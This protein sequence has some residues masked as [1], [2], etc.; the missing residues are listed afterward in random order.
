[1][2]TKTDHNKILHIL[3][4]SA[5]KIALLII[6][7]FILSV[8]V[9][10]LARL[11]PGDP[12]HS[13]FGDAADRMT[14]AQKAA[15]MDKMGLN[16]SVI[17]QYIVWITNFF[18][19]NLGISYQYKQPVVNIIGNLWI[20]TLVL[21][22]LS[23][24]LTFVFAIFVGVFCAVRQNSIIDN[25]IRKVGTASSTIPSFF[26]ALIFILIFS[27][28]L[29]LLPMGGAYEPGGE[30][31]TV[32]RVVHLILPLSVMILSHLWY[33]AYMIRNKMIEELR[34]D[35]VLLLKVKGVSRRIIIWKHCFRNILPSLIAI[36]TVS[37][38]H[39]IGGT[40]VVETVFS[41]P[42]LGKLSFESA[43]YH[44]YNMLSA[45]CLITGTLVLISNM[46]GEEFSELADPRIKAGSVWALTMKRG[47]SDKYD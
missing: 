8:L 43:V 20:N 29:K 38:P 34:M 47:G 41:Y 39:I 23:Y 46:I 2:I 28:T 40:Y 15:A 5:K 14:A 21:G 44:D 4:D 45:L 26:D 25:I 19:G 42:G 22:G 10:L 6:F 16:D 37:I 33:Y 35:Y 17:K 27:V 1:M 11:A 32:G 30:S 3:G 18:Q 13:Y 24:I 12:L 9:F 36:M 7:L 31:D